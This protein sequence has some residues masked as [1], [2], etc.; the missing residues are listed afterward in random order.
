MS[1]L[2][3]KRLV[4]SYPEKTV[5]SS[6]QMVSYDPDAA[7]GSRMGRINVQDAVEAFAGN[8]A[9]A[10]YD[11][12]A[13]VEAITGQS[14][15]DAVYLSLGGRSGVFQWDSS[16]L[17]TEVAADTLQGVYIAPSSDATGASGAWVRELNG[18]V[19]PDMF[20]Y[21]SDGADYSAVMDGF[22]L[23]CDTF[24]ITGMFDGESIRAPS[25]SRLEITNSLRLRA[26]RKPIISGEFTADNYPFVVVSGSVDFE[27]IKFIGFA[28]LITAGDGYGG[29]MP[30]SLAADIDLI[31]VNNCDFDDC[32]RPLFLATTAGG[33]LLKTL[34]LQNNTINGKTGATQYGWAGLYANWAD[35]ESA[36]VRRNR[37]KN[38]DATNAGYAAG[39]EPL[40][41]GNGRAI[42]VGSTVVVDSTYEWAGW[43]VS[44]N[45][46][47]NI[48]DSRNKG[49]GV[50]PEVGGCRVTGAR[51]SRVCDNV[52][53]NVLSTGAGVDDD[54]EGVYAQLSDSVINSNR[55]KNCGQQ[56]GAIVIKGR[57][58]ALETDDATRPEGFNGECANNI[59]TQSGTFE[60][61]GVAVY[62][63]G[64]DVHHNSV[65]G[66][67]GDSTRYAAFWTN[68]QNNS[69]TRFH[70]NTAKNTVGRFA[71]MNTSYGY[72]MGMDDNIVDGMDGSIVTGGQS[73]SAFYFLNV[74][75]NGLNTGGVPL[76]S[77]SVSRNKIANLDAAG[78]AGDIEVITVRCNG[79]DAEQIELAGNKLHGSADIGVNLASGVIDVMQ[80]S[81]NRL[82]GSADWLATGATVSGL[83]ASDNGDWLYAEVAANPPSIA[84]GAQVVVASGV[85]TDMQSRDHVVVTTN[86]LRQGLDY[87]VDVTDSSG[88]FDVYMQNNTGAAIDLSTTTF[89]VVSEK[90]SNSL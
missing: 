76:A 71:F 13:G 15:N 25:L 90:L 23:F 67:G 29:S 57:N 46:F 89:R 41:F 72:N 81:A 38:I 55:L 20:G 54:C 80:I 5:S 2:T 69:G 11:S 19:T 52:G 21:A 58:E 34:D 4:G 50:N 87:W 8:V 88:G 56:G 44:K 51:Q 22:F 3:R 61:S 59:V 10:R 78:Y 16:D 37:I 24:A 27:C 42:V 9:V 74:D 14:S 40:V 47:E 70:H 32:R 7:V 83:S 62:T 31:R 12:I 18:Y 45:H 75:G 49:N 39:G 65:T 66:A 53:K 63:S 85:I 79:S 60:S 43:D 30:H 17:S 6:S 36:I 26:L 64:W 68:A 1:N 84:D 77:A 28:D 82:D 73:L 33:A 48:T 35:L 86:T